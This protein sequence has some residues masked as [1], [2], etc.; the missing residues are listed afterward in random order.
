MGII[1][2]TNEIYEDPIIMPILGTDNHHQEA[3]PS[4]DQ[5]KLMDYELDD[6][7][8]YEDEMNI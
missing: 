4:E 3:I 6:R 7:P 8:Y 5:Y 2:E 1:D